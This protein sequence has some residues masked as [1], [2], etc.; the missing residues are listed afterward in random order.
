MLRRDGVL[1]AQLSVTIV[2]DWP[3]ARMEKGKCVDVDFIVCSRLG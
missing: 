1:S 2:I 3:L